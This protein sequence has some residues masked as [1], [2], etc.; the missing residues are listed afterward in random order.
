MMPFH[1]FQALKNDFVLIEL[2]EGGWK[3]GLREA[4]SGRKMRVL[5]PA[6]L[7]AAVCDR[8]AG[9]GCDQMMVILPPAPD[10]QHDAS[11]EIYNPD[12]RRAEA[13]GNGTR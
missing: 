2:E 11:I 12:G 10:G 9:I 5:D 13:C 8:R 3:G 1:K 6:A 7:A 4:D